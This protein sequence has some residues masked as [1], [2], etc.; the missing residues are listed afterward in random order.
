MQLDEAKKKFLNTWADLASQ[1]GISKSMS[2]VHAYLLI[3]PEEVNTD[4]IREALNLSIGSVNTSLNN[5]IDWGLIYKTKV[6]GSRKDHYFAEKDMWTVFRQILKN[7]KEKE[8]KPL[9]KTLDELS[10]AKTKD[11]EAGKEFLKVVRE[12]KRVSNQAD[13]ALNTLVKS[14]ESWFDNPFFKM[15]Q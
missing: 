11:D 7:R 14:E 10:K 15:I 13:S 5:L 2:C 3:Q 8:L 9:L 4:D 1:W 6:P 12:I